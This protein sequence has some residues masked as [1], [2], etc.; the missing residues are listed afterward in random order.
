[1]SRDS[2][3]YILPLRHKSVRKPLWIV[4]L[5]YFITI[6]LIWKGDS[7]LAVNTLVDNDVNMV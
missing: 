6:A 2:N 7:A 5:Y 1:M 3:L 4:L